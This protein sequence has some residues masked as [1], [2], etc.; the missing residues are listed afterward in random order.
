[1]TK[2]DIARDFELIKEDVQADDTITQAV[3]TMVNGIAE[4]FLEALKA[5]DPVVL[6]NQ[7]VDIVEVMQFEAQLFGHAIAGEAEDDEDEEEA[8]DDK[9]A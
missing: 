7:I 9:P 5:T 3:A 6:R 2:E 4:V 1:M 8:E